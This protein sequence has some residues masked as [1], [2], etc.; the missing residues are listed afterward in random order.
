M[1]R[2]I[3]ILTSAVVVAVATLSAQSPSSEGPYKVIKTAKVGGAGGFDYVYADVD[4]RR[5]YIPRTGNPPR[6]SVYNLDT[7][8]PVGEIP[9]A[10]ARGVAVSTKSGHGFGSSKPVSMWDS[11]SITPMKTR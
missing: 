6:I 8:E 5:L 2:L 7:L 9:N 1:Y 3:S 10:N 11:K 4:G